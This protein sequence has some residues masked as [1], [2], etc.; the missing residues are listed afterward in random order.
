MSAEHKTCTSCSRENNNTNFNCPV[1]GDYRLFTDWRPRCA[2]QYVD[3]IGNK[4]E[5]ALDYRMYLTHN[6][7]D[8]MQKNALN[9]YLK[10][11]CG[12]CVDDPSWNDGTMLRQY[13]SQQCNARTCTFRQNDPWGLGR[14]RKYYDED[15]DKK[16][17]QE[18]I[19]QKEKENAYFK[20]TAQCCGTSTDDMAYYPIDGG[21]QQ[22]Y[23]RHAVPSG[24]ALMQGGDRLKTSSFH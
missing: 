10:A 19:A 5:S 15:L 9:A 23:S 6:A 16:M 12:P 17:N 1:K 18:F 20:S 7:S 22:D 3:M 14:E 24:G 4:L 13:D 11:R 21:V 8:L 2:T